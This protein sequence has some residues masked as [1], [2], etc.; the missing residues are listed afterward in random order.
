MGFIS[1]CIAWK[2]DSVKKARSEN[3]D[4]D[5]DFYGSSMAIFYGTYRKFT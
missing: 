1:Y 2:C 4:E 5:R 3:G